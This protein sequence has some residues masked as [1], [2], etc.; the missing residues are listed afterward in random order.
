MVGRET[1][2]HIRFLQVVI[3]LALA[4]NS[5]Q[6]IKSKITKSIYIKLS[7]DQGYDLLQKRTSM[8][9][10]TSKFPGMD[11]STTDV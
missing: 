10:Y 4:T 11:V 9:I 6:E 2:N 8:R 7:P 5:F 1:I 3:V